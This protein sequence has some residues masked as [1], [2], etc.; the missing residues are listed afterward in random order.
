MV[1]MIDGGVIISRQKHIP[2][3]EHIVVAPSVELCIISAVVFNSLSALPGVAVSS[4]DPV[5]ALYIC[6]QCN[7]S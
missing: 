7:F 4:P 3:H 1:Y 2:A 5:P 6:Q